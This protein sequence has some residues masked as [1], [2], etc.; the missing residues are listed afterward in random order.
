MQMQ[1]QR[2]GAQLGIGLKAL[3]FP[4]LL[5]V[6]GYKILVACPIRA[7]ESVHVVRR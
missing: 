4:L 6:R 2:E 7:I 5:Q 3:E 1:M